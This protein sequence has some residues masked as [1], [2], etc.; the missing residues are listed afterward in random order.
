LNG[1]VLGT[2]GLGALAATLP[3]QLALQVL[4]WRQIMMIVAAASFAGS[5]ILF[6][7]APEAPQ[8][9]TAST[10]IDQLRGMTLVYR[11][12]LFWRIAPLFM[13]TTGAMLSF[14]SLWAAP[15]LKDVARLMPSEI[16]GDLLALT[17]L[18]TG[19]Y[20]GVGML[21][22][23]LNRRGVSLMRIVHIGAALF[24][25]SQAALVLP[26]GAGRWATLIGMG[27][28][29]NVN[30]L[31]YP[32]LATHFPAGL[33]GRANTALN[34]FVFVGAFV[35]Q[36]AVGA[37]IDL[38]PAAT[39]DSYPVPAYQ[40]AFGLMLVVEIAAWAWFPWPTTVAAATKPS[41]LEAG[42]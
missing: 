27:C 22:T 6:T 15:W 39:P 32:V 28:V 19:G 13:A 16:A 4:D 21:A 40:A 23:W 38:F 29:A 3:T 20:V 2:G 5:L 18:Q 17:A 41:D 35:L 33:M 14:Q 34:L 26:T 42:R 7:V 12:R 10:L 8:R 9:P 11:D 36:Y 30:L 1:W 24:I 25:A 37:V 31:L